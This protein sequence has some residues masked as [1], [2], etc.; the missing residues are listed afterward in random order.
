MS[1]VAIVSPLDGSN[2]VTVVDSEFV[3]HT[4]SSVAATRNGRFGTS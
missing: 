3:T 2:R 1:T 4:A